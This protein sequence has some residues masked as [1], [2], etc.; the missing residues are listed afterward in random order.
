M[1][2]PLPPGVPYRRLSPAPENVAAARRFVRAA[3]AGAAPDVLDTAELLTDELVTNAVVHARTEAEVWAWADGGRAQVRVSDR[4]PEWGVVPHDRHPYASTGRGLALLRELAASYGVHSDAERKTVWFD[5]WPEATE[6]PTSA[7]ETAEPSGRTVTVALKDVPY[8]LYRAARQH[9]EGL[10]RELFLV[11]FGGGPAEVPPRDLAAAQDASHLIS[12]CVAA[13]VEQE[14]PDSTTLSVLVRFAADAAPGVATLRRVVDAAEAAA[15]Q[16]D[17]L[18]L[19]AL[20]QIRAFRHWLFDQIAGQL[21]GAS[22][23]SWTRAPG[24]PGASPAQLAPWDASEVEAADVPTVAADDRNR[25]IAVN[26][27]AASL[28]GWPAHDLV[29]RRL[30]VLMPEH[31]RAR[32]RAAFTSLLLTGESR[33]LGRL[34]PVPALH[35]DGRAIPVRLFI[36]TQEAVDGRTVFV[37]QLTA[38]AAPLTPPEPPEDRYVTRPVPGPARLPTAA[39]RRATVV[40]GRRAAEWL[41]VFATTSRALTSTLDVGEMLRRVCRVLTTHLADWC[42][43]DLLDEHGRAERVCIVHRD[44]RAPVSTEHLGRLPAAPESTRDPLLRVLRGAGPLLVTD[45]SPLRRTKSPL[46]AWQLDLVARLGGSSAVVAPLRARR[47]VVGALTM[48]RVRDEEPFA[49]D[50][51]VLISELARSIALGVD[52]ARLHQS[53][54]S[55][56]EQLQRALLPELPQA[57]QLELTARYVPSSTT[58]EVGGD[59]Y[60]AFVLPDGD[61][62]LVIGD[63]SGH[64]LQAAVAMSTLR[65]MLRGIAVD[66]REPPGEVLR[67]LDLAST[68]LSPQSTATCVYGVLKSDGGRWSLHHSSAGHLPPLLT[69]PSGDARYLDTGGGLLI[70]MD[71]EVPRPS[72]HDGLPPY[73]TLLFFTDGLIERRG[74]PIDDAME[75]LRRHTAAYARAPLDVFCDELVIQLGADSTDDIALLALRPTPG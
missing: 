2:C 40:D 17:L 28:L 57:D 34:L 55:N 8:T 29:G 19:P 24:T 73:S 38:A 62:A 3:L 61:T 63:V 68:T 67:R 27:S 31:L 49:K 45:L 72:G 53:T 35:R 52:D 41:P 75:R 50:D 48:V 60:D 23:T 33:I 51:I 42:A 5:L 59:W 4:R 1:G 74:E 9:W 26:H 18:A 66:R 69:T 71:P 43:A 11:A 10:L 54:R 47:D 58:A 65:N 22:P 39:T 37:A 14:T 25:I 15:R 16:G 12:A 70:G 13:A 56:A 30:T 36:Q 44:P 21:S 20:P 32:H 7:W 46:D 64:D 6:P